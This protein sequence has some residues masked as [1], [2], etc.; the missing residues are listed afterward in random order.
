M[1]TLN[2]LMKTKTKFQLAVS[3]VTCMMFQRKHIINILI[4]QTTSIKINDRDLVFLTPKRFAVTIAFVLVPPS[5]HS[6]L[7]AKRD[8][9]HLL[10]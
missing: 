6:F 5:Q 2:A 4:P 8:C 10:E 3:V 9:R 7:E 1:F